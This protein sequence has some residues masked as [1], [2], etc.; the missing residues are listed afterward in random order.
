MSRWLFSARVDLLMFLGVA[1]ASAALA[2]L[3]QVLG[4]EGEMPGWAFV[5]FVIGIDVAHV[6]S[7]SFRVY[8]D[9]AELRRRPALYFGAPCVALALG[10]GAHAVSS[11]FFWRALAYVA[12]W[13]FIRQ[14]TGWMVLYGRRADDA[15][16]VINLDVAVLWAAT[17]GPVVWWHANL[18]RAFWWFREHDFVPGAPR[19]VGVAALTIDAGVLALWLVAHVLQRR[20]HPGKLALVAATWVAWFGGIV[21]AKSDFA[22]TVMNVS[23]HGVPYLVLTRRYQ[24]GRLTE[25]GAYGR[26]VRLLRWGVPVFMGALVAVAFAEETLWDRLVWHDHPELFGPSGVELGPWAV[27]VVPLLTLPQL[28]HYLLDGFIWR[29]RRDPSLGQRLGWSAR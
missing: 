1:L 28:T 15:E 8:L 14:Q 5:V 25:A 24:L 21:L 18:P 4:L 9:G 16:R 26:L 23:L 3:A 10:L 27:L 29:G 2:A 19:W 6:W 20:V 13:H 11:D 22:F 7:T 12:V 17:L